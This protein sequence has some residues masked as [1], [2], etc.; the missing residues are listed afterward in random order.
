M[1]KRALAP[2]VYVIVMNE[3]CYWNLPEALMQ[4]VE[5]IEGVYVFNRNEHTYCCEMT[6]SYWLEFVE[7]RAI[8]KEG[9][10]SRLIDEIDNQVLSASDEHG[11]YYHVYEIDTAIDSGRLP[12]FRYGNPFPGKRF[13]GAEV[14]SAVAEGH[15]ANPAI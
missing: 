7:N 14:L 13:P 11:H 12:A 6:P 10:P 1:S 15:R 9:T 5:R 4:H 3:T 8:Y 2:D